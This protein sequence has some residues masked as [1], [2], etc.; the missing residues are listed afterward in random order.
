MSEARL[1]PSDA[2]SYQT[3]PFLKV[4]KAYLHVLEAGR[5]KNIIHGLI[6][7]DVTEA[8]RQL[9]QVQDAG[10]HIS[11]TAFLMYAVAQAVAEDRIVHAYRCRQQLILFDDVDV[12]TQIEVEAEGQKIVKSMIIR[13]ANRKS[14]TEISE[15]I[16]C[17]RSIDPAAGP[18]AERR[19][20]GTLAFVSIPRPLRS[21]AWRAVMSNPRWFKRLGG[22]VGMSSIGMFGPGGGW[23][24]P[25][26]PPTLMITVGGIA[27]KPRYLN[28]QL[29][30]REL[31]DLT[32][33]VDH[34][35][36]DGAPA[37]RFAHRL[38]ELVEA[39]DGLPSPD[40]DRRS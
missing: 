33:S 34:D 3:R 32:I 11:F 12:N 28:D 38:A 9:R 31:L 5:R 14:V 37:A 39:A 36:V 30:P 29:E 25:I 16:E 24:I 17:G 15:E 22:T 23:G 27:T 18:A 19:Y 7:I 6:E 13:A 20:R 8:R 26:A 1:K 40:L 10:R 4:R 2:E 21:L 35:I